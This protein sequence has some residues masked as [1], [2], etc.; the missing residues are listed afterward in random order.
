MP[1]FGLDP[2]GHAARWNNHLAGGDDEAF[3][4]ALDDWTSY[5]ERLGVE[6]VSEGA[7]LLHRR[8]GTGHTTRVDAI[9]DDALDHAGDQ[10]QRAFA[11]RARLAELGKPVELL[12]AR[13]AIGAP[14]RLERELEPGGGRPGVVAAEVEMAE[15]T[16]PTVEASSNTLEVVAALDG[17]TTLGDVVQRVA[18]K[19]GL[20]E[21]QTAELR[22]ESLTLMRELLELGALEF[23]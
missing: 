18:E 21:K 1:I 20:S 7:V 23:H 19:L 16:N 10:I 3:R 4:A 14:V 9:D 11:A 17:G 12:D 2:L 15:G 22:Q 13:L 8:A 5:L 6:M